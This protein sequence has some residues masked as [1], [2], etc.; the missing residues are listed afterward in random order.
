MDGTTVVVTGAAGGIGRAV[1]T[2]FAER[3]ADV[4]ASVRNGTDERARRSDDDSTTTDLFAALDGVDVVTADAR[5]EFDAERLMERAA[6]VNGAIDVVI[7]CAAVFHGS[8][9]ERPLPEESYA[10]FDDE[11]RTNA[12]GVFAACKEALPHLAAD[13]R[14]LVPSGKVAREPSAGYGGYAVSKAAAEA[15]ARGFSADVDQTVGVVDP[16]IVAT[17]LTGGQ[18]RDPADAADLFV[19]A[20][21]EAD[22]DELDGGVV[23]LKAWKQATR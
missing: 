17:D 15:V 3:G 16:G 1:V 18:G 21:T 11:F 6:R 12:R 7:P 2:A 19:W 5:D 22:A 14:V 8:P 13:G 4:V 9:S 23:D 10:A 20:A